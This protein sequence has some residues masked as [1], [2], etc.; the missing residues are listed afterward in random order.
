M[1]DRKKE[2]YSWKR[3]LKSRISIALSAIILAVSVPEHFASVFAAE[4]TADIGFTDENGRSDADRPEDAGE[5]SVSD[6]P[7]QE[8]EESARSGDTSYEFAAEKETGEEPPSGDTAA[9]ITGESETGEAEI[10]EDTPSGETTAESA[11]RT[12]EGG[13]TAAAMQDAEFLID[14]P[15]P[16]ELG[17][18]TEQEQKN[19]AISGASHRFS[20][21][22]LIY[23]GD[24]GKEG[25]NAHFE[26]V[27][28][29][30]DASLIIS[31]TGE[32]ED[33]ELL[34]DLLMD[35]GNYY[36][37]LYNDNPETV[38]NISGLPTVRRL[39]ISG[40]TR[41]GD[42]NFRSP[43][44]QIYEIS[45]KD[46]RTIGKNAFCECTYIGDLYFP[47]TL[48]TIEESAFAHSG[49]YSITFMGGAVSIGDKAFFET[50]NLVG[51]FFNGMVESRY[52]KAGGTSLLL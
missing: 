36:T 37:N 8:A 6:G 31:G 16:E 39:S 45:I 49:L 34:N 4:K 27:V 51:A 21:G 47:E 44:Q 13:D 25:D 29:D 17:E 28:D 3:T 2:K 48:R 14:E 15:M 42:N 40:V 43:Y 22:K 33:G 9:E 35:Y 7:D 5:G 46:V 30:K 1:P 20:D 50:G 32:L 10:G 41:I 11:A 38:K 26:L 19:V 23:F 12:E 18:E 52:N 24:F